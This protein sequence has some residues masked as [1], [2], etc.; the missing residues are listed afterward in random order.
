MRVVGSFGDTGEGF[1][2]L[3]SRVAKKNERIKKMLRIHYHTSA[4]LGF[5]SFGFQTRRASLCFE[6]RRA[7]IREYSGMSELLEAI[8]PFLGETFSGGQGALP[9]GPDSLPLPSQEALP[10]GPNSPTLE[11]G[12]GEP[13]SIRPN[14]SLEASM[15]A[16]ILKLER[17]N[18]YYFLLDKRNGEY[19][20]EIRMALRN[21][22]SQ[23]EYNRLLDFEHRD[24]R[25]R[26]TK[27]ECFTLFQ[28]VLSQH[29]ALSKDA[30]YDPTE[31]FMD[32]FSEKRDTMN[33]EYSELNPAENEIFFIEQ[34]KNDLR[35]R[36]HESSYIL[37]LLG[38]GEGGPSN[39]GSEIPRVAGDEAGPP[40][41]GRDEAGSDQPAGSDSPRSLTL[42][43]QSLL[44]EIL[45]G[46]TD[47]GEEVGP[48]SRRRP[49]S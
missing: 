34:V 20:N 21:C 23:K 15:R 38:Y 19:W 48:S 13:S 43:D 49:L 1:D 30:A 29:P 5:N 33:Q 2:S 11:V 39:S 45:G 6:T 4:S 41:Q 3:S 27:F 22:S 44:R 32:F 18:S 42:S 17:A 7:I 9:Q 35:T 14:D 46:D 28:G 8:I 40:H 25:I 12:A 31:S 26:E 37:K 47:P 36:G 16:R 10:P 24:L